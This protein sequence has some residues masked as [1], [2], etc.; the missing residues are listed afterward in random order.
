MEHAKKMMLVDPKF[1][2]PSITEKAQNKI[3]DAITEILNSD[4]PDDVKVKRYSEAARRFSV[5]NEPSPAPSA[6]SK[7]LTESDVLH[8]IP[9]A[10]RHT[11][12]R[13]LDYLKRDGNVQ[14]KDDGRVTYKNETFAESNIVDLLDAALSK[15]VDEYP[16][17]MHAFGDTLRDISTPCA[18]VNNERLLKRINRPIPKAKKRSAKKTQRWIAYESRK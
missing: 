3:D 5:I 15:K 10:T 2:R 6:D 13:L 16:K 12:K 18:L 4:L 9:T 8:S 17:G 14:Y 1:Y 7:K 11:A